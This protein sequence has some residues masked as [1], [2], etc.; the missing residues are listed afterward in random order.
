[1]EQEREINYWR[2]LDWYGFFAIVAVFWGGGSEGLFGDYGGT[3]PGERLG[4]W[5]AFP[6]TLWAAITMSWARAATRVRANRDERF[7]VY[8]TMFLGFNAWMMFGPTFGETGRP[9]V[10][11]LLLMASTLFTIHKARKWPEW[12]DEFEAAR[13]AKEES[14]MPGQDERESDPRLR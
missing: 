1:V 6:L 2:L 12:V 5:I 13:A 14:L 4:P 11:L 10:G 7:V 8:C 3:L 9:G